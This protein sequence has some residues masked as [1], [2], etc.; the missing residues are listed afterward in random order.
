PFDVLVVCGS[1]NLVCIFNCSISGN[2]SHVQTLDL[3]PNAGPV[4]RVAWDL[5]GTILATAQEGGQ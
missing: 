5:T 2:L 4:W 3:G 1:S